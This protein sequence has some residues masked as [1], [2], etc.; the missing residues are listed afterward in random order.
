MIS[1]DTQLH[2]MAQ[3]HTEYAKQA[4]AMDNTAITPQFLNSV[5]TTLHS[6][7]LFAGKKK[8]KPTEHI[9]EGYAS[10]TFI[11]QQCNNLPYRLRVY[12]TIQ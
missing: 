6:W 5:R 2:K 7:L 11:S 12:R 10:V 8:N 3:K 9:P 4:M 1:S